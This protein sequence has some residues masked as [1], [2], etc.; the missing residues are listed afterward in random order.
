MRAR[1]AGLSDLLIV[2]GG[3]GWRSDESLQAMASAGSH[4]VHYLGRV[5][6]SDLPLVM[7]GAR[8]FVSLATAEGFGMPALEAMATGVPVVVANDAGLAEV[9]G[10]AGLPVDPDNLDEVAEAL[11]RVTSDANLRGDLIARG[12]KRAAGFTW[13]AAGRSVWH[14]IEQ[15]CASC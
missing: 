15:A 7:A 8:G 9:V 3:D 11:V 6:A 1:D 4:A 12:L 13:D 2:A 5:P 14:A 10:D